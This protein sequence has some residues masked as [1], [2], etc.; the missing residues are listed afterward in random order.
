MPKKKTSKQPTAAELRQNQISA[1]MAEAKNN[2]DKNRHLIEK[3]RK[4]P[5]L[6]DGV[7]K[8]LCADLRRVYAVPRHI[9]GPSA[10]RRRYRELG[11][12]S[13]ELVTYLI[14]TW[15][16]FQRQADIMP[17]LGVRTIERKISMTLR[18]QQVSQYADKYVK[19]WDGAYD[20]LDMTQESVMLQIGSDFHSKYID[21]FARRVWMEVAEMNQPDGVRFNGDGPDFPQLSTHRQLPG[22]FA[23]TVQNEVDCW[24]QFMRDTREAAPDA[25][26]KWILGNHD[27]RLVNAI[28][29]AMPILASMRDVSFANLFKLDELETGLVAKCT[30]LNPAEKLRKQDIARNWETLPDAKG[31]PFWTTVHG[32]L[33]GTGAPEKH[34]RRFMTYGT[35][36]HLHNPCSVS[37]GSYA[38]GPLRWWQTGTMGWP[39]AIAETYVPGPVDALGWALTFLVV[40]LYPRYRH[41]HVEEVAITDIATYQGYYWEATPTELA[42]REAMME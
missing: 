21:P 36:G 35:N 27:V 20:S 28:A 8:E 13:E 7:R 25:D 34:M 33:C 19:P 11:D 18:A 22:H 41:V 14:G 31:N 38:T 3:V 12:Y 42:A 1:M 23:L 39:E 24:T 16:E 9:L 10:S 4:D 37:G 26:L 15:A 30:F 40:T 29:D 17:S 32:F 2:R 5:S 6:A